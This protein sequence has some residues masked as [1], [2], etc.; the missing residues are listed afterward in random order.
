M[1]LASALLVLACSATG[2]VYSNADWFLK[3]W[4]NDYTQPN[5]R[6]LARWEPLL[7]SQ[8]KRHRAEELPRIIGLIDAFIAGVDGGFD[9]VRAACLGKGLE[10][11]YERHVRFLAELAAP[12]LADLTPEQIDHLATR[13]AEDNKDQPKTDES[14]SER[15]LRKR[16][17]RFTSAAE[18]LVGPLEDKQI[19]LVNE[20]SRRIPDTG[21][22]WFNYQRERQAE[23]LT[24]LRTDAG[25]ARIQAQLGAWWTD[26]SGADPVVKEAR[27][28]LTAS[29]ADLVAGI[30]TSLTS[31]QRTQMR[32]HLEELKKELLR[33]QGKAEVVALPCPPRLASDPRPSAPQ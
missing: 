2:F 22:A 19:A 30:G 12:L 29:L 6:Q 27:E 24:L 33:Q 21:R 7:A 13:F 5:A 17:K 25:T 14:G 4:A 26:F 1:L 18:W 11:L 31:G 20:V 23:L 3:R 15:R 10:Q 28:A 9:Q 16:A 32:H 8:L